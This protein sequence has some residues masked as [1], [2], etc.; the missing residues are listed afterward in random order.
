VREVESGGAQ[1]Y[2]TADTHFNETG[3]RVAAEFL[4]PVIES[5]LSGIEKRPGD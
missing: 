2:G 1:L 5:H 4:L 3:H